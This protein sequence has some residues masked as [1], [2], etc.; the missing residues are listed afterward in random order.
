[1]LTSCIDAEESSLI[2]E[3]GRRHFFQAML[4]NQM[5]VLDDFDVKLEQPLC[6]QIL[7]DSI[8]IQSIFLENCCATGPIFLRF[9]AAEVCHRRPPS[10]AITSLFQRLDKRSRSLVLGWRNPTNP[11]WSNFRVSFC[12]LKYSE[13]GS[14]DA[15]WRQ[16]LFFISQL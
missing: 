2:A 13:C 8:A 15:S 14:F 3:L 11:T 6:G 10:D 12:C 5:K 9:E 7:G 1:M 16:R 4:D